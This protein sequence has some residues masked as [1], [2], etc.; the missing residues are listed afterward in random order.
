[1]LLPKG[2]SQLYAI[3]NFKDAGR[4]TCGYLGE[5]ESINV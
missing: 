3:N 2:L 4:D 5:Y 1:M